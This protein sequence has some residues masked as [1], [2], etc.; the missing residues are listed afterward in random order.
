MGSGYFW[1][2]A[3]IIRWSACLGCMVLTAWN[4]G[5]G[6]WQAIALACLLCWIGMDLLRVDVRAARYRSASWSLMG[7]IVRYETSETL[8]EASLEELDRRVL[9]GLR[10][11][12]IRR[13]PA[14]IRHKKR[15]CDV[16]ILAWYGLLGLA[17]LLY[18]VFG[19]RWHWFRPWQTIPL[20]GVFLGLLALLS[21]RHELAAANILGEAIERYEFESQA[22][23][24][25]LR[26]A[27]ARARL[28]A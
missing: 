19:H 10:T 21:R 9:E 20:M 4:P 5:G 12:R 13:A 25:D 1:F 18:V 27:D 16:T 6:L 14:W 24:E 7:A 23:E 22:T 28:I 17:I 26:E 8:A 11:R 3:Q 15:R 2:A